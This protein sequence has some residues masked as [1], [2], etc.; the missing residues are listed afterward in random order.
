[1]NIGDFVT[2]RSKGDIYYLRD[3]EDEDSDGCWGR[4]FRRGETA[5]V[6]GIKPYISGYEHTSNV[7]VLTANMQLGWIKEKYITC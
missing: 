3:P 7:L 2:C 4:E 6:L 5:I 1:M